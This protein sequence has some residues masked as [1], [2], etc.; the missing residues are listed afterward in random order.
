MLL[1][2]GLSLM[3]CVWWL[4]CPFV[5]LRSSVFGNG[6]TLSTARPLGLKRLAGTMLPGNGRPVT[7][8]LITT[9]RPALSKVWEKS[10]LLSRSVGIVHCSSEPGFSVIGASSE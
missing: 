10:P 8:S 6:S 3:N 1:S 7:G 4:N 2:F 5:K 9:S